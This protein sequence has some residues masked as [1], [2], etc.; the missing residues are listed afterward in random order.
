MNK[1]VVLDG[2]GEFTKELADRLT[3]EGF[4]VS[5]IADDGEVGLEYIRQFQPD[6]VI[7]GMVLKAID[8]FGVLDKLKESGEKRDIIAVGSF[9]DDAVVAKVLAKGAKY[10]LMKPVSAG[11]VVERVKELTSEKRY[12]A[13]NPSSVSFRERKN[14]ASLDEK[15]SNIFISIGIPASIKGYG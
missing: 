5:G 12:A 3:K 11:L 9:N 4:E 14:Y 13:Q 15:I 1:I 2:N 10:Y 6:V 7:V 8:G